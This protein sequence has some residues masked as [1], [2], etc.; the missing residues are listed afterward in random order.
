VRGSQDRETSRE[1]LCRARALDRYG[2]GAKSGVAPGAAAQHGPQCREVIPPGTAIRLR[3]RPAAI[4][5]PTERRV[6]QVHNDHFHVVS[7]SAAMAFVA[8]TIPSGDVDAAV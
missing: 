6:S 4:V 3:G 1:S 8:S 5:A 7:P 2:T